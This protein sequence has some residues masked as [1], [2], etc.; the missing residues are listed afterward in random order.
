MRRRAV[1]GLLATGS[2]AGCVGFGRSD[3]LA[4]GDGCDIGMSSGAFLPR[5]FTTSVGESVTWKNTSSRGHTVTAYE[6]DLPE[7][8]AYFATG[9][10]DGQAAAVD[11][12]FDRFGGRLDSGDTFTVTFEVAGRYPYYCIPHEADDMRGTIRVEDA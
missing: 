10:F 4:C 1:L 9:G 6:A 3:Q 7:G 11:A 12:W 8:A 5:E 2:L